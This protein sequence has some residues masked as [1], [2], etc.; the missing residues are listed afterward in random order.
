MS[1]QIQRRRGTAVEHTSFTGVVGEITID[2]TNNTVR[3]HDATTV[4]GH[5]LAK[6]SELPVAGVSFGLFRKVDPTE[7][8]WSKTGAFTV[9]TAT[10]LHVEVFGTVH[11]IASGATVTM[12]GS[13]VSGTD[14]AIWAKTDGTL[15][16]TDN[17]TSPPTANARKVGGFHFAPGGNATAQS[18]GDT[19]PA[20]NEFSMWDLKYRPTC[21]DPR[22]M[23]L[24]GDGFWSDIYLTGVDA[25]TNGSSKFNVTIADGSSPPKVPTMFGGN[26]STTYGSYTWFE[27]MELATAF[28]KKNPTQQ[29]FM[30]LAFGT[31][32]AT[33]G[34]TDPGSTILRNTFT[35]KW[36][37][38]LSTGNMRV[39]ARDRAGPFAAASFNANT[40]GRGS[41][42]NA[43]NAG[44]LGGDFNNGVDAGSRL[45]R[46]N[47][48]AS[49]S[50]SGIGSR[51][52]CDHLQLD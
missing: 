3:V 21:P 8:A 19:T 49:G 27:C 30:S 10:Q 17:H 6:F 16:A 18:G 51:F 22:G 14:Y 15:E 50:S 11:T 37:V 1:T 2:T 45:S 38:M 4:G 41:E 36:G 12:P 32:E 28:G 48:A 26:G 40:E 47:S 7:V 31:T 5:R 43:P 29:E 9:V 39:W 42:F 20:I 52:V 33:S 34:G 46:W 44:L 24:V 13:S 35:S 25:I 23:T